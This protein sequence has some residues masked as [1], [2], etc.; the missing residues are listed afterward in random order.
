M[1]FK[2]KKTENYTVMSNHHLQDPE[3]SLKA[4]GLLSIMLSLP[5][6]WDYSS[7]G[8]QTF[9][10]DGETAMRNTLKELEDHHY[11]NRVPVREK[12]KISD[13]IYFIYEIP[14]LDPV[15]DEPVVENVQLENPVQ[16]NT[17]IQNTNKLNIYIEKTV[18]KDTG[19]KDPQVNE[20]SV[21][22]FVDDYNTICK[23]LPQCTLLSDRRKRAIR[24]ILSKFK[25]DQ[26]LQVFKICEESP[27]LTGKND[28]GWKANID[29]ILREDKFISILEGRYSSRRPTA[30]RTGVRRQVVSQEEKERLKNGEQF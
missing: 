22:N 25:Y 24:K 28:R 3:L 6:D 11:L 19:K 4:K 5:E 30:E 29:F 12:G 9:C 15:E 16:Q 27:F 8:L 1:V 26:V 13:W 2:V 10:S 17:N 14:T 18:S 23:S 7:A 20:E 21:K